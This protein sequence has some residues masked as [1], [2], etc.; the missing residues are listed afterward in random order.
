MGITSNVENQILDYL[1][2]G[3]TPT[4]GFDDDGRS[5]FNSSVDI[6]RIP[7]REYPLT[8][9]SIAL[10]TLALYSV[11]L[12]DLRNRAADGMSKEH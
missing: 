3:W 11:V 7:I 2:V 5:V 4:G 6:S 12:P 8:N 10:L 1:S 9:L